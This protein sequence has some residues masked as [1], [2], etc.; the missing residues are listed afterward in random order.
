LWICAPINRAVDDKAAKSLLGESFK[1]QLK[2]DGV[3]SRITFICSKTDDISIKEASDSLG[4]EEEMAADWEKI[5]ENEQKQKSLKNSLEKLKESREVYGEVLNDTEDAI[6]I[7]DTLK[8]DAEDGK[9]VFAS[10]EKPSE[11]KKRKHSPSPKKSRKKHAGSDNQAK[12]SPDEGG[13]LFEDIEK[14]L[15]QLKATKKDARQARAKVDAEA[16]EIRAQMETLTSEKSETEIRMS[17][18]C[19][20]GRNKY[21]KGAIQQDFAAGIRELDQ[22]NA[23]EEDADNFDPEEDIRDYD[24]VARSLP[25]FAVSSRAYQKLKGR[26]LRDAAVPGFRAPEET[27]IPQLQ[28]HCKKLT[29]A[30]RAANCRRYLNSLS[31]L[32]LSI[33]LWANNDGTGANLSDSQRA[34]EGRFLQNSLQTLEK[35]LEKAVQSC[36]TEMK[37]ALSENIYEHFENMIQMAID[38]APKT[39][40]KWGAPVNK[41]DRSQGGY[42]WSTYKAICRRDGVYSNAQGLH[43]LNN[44]LTEP[45][46][47][48]L[49]NHWEKVFA[50][51]LPQVLQGFTRKSKALLSAF[52]REIEVRTRN[53]GS[54]VAG[55][56][57]LAQQLRTYEAT[58]AHLTTEMT[59]AINNW[60]KDSNREFVPVIAENL[61]SAYEWCASETGGGQYARMKEHMNTHVEQMRHTMFTDSCNE[62]K[63]QLTQMCRQVEEAMANKTDE[64]F[65]LMRR[66]YLTV[67][68]GAQIPKGELMPKW[69]RRMRSEIADAI[70]KREEGEEEREVAEADEEVAAPADQAAASVGETVEPDAESATPSIEAGA[71]VRSQSEE[72]AEAASDAQSDSSTSQDPSKQLEDEA[73]RLSDHDSGVV[74]KEE[75]VDSDMSD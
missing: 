25:V 62:V 32:L 39:S 12:S 20:E 73:S 75:P 69:E 61:A 54:S 56:A 1:R 22:E 52:H 65:M 2:Y 6:D 57:M 10:V 14:K 63:T 74:P 40:A 7:W 66:D 64:V 47:R 27:E 16:K 36:L 55:L 11:D 5:D 59:E 3:F 37:D 19:I 53:N 34:A 38:E 28:A 48:H 13:P 15:E 51:K 49:A 43:D 23:E 18:I 33:N 50:R 46:M 35:D 9:T 26:L 58:F 71:G 41:V 17:A 30:G 8:D 68:N 67:I 4:L 72:E 31:Q 29:E 70:H 44:Q 42:Y 21:S 60:Q 45:I 24:Q